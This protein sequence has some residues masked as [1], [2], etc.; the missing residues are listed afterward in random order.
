LY[1]LRRFSS[2]KKFFAFT[3]RA[4]RSSRQQL[5]LHARDLKSAHNVQNNRRNMATTPMPSCSL[6]NA[7]TLQPCNT[8]LL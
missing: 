7:A 4:L 1:T 6:F 5:Y 3:L 8:A 2:A